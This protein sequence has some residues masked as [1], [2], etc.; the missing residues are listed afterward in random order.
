MSSPIR[1]WNKISRR[2]QFGHEVQYAP[3]EDCVL[4][5]SKIRFE[6]VS[7]DHLL[8]VQVVD[9]WVLVGK[10]GLHSKVHKYTLLS[11]LRAVIISMQNVV[12]FASADR[13]YGM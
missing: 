13:A 11:T 9:A 3:C 5:H 1:C 8:V 12:F 7:P 10:S 6:V 4:H 2:S